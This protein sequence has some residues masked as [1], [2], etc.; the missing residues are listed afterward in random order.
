MFTI[1]LGNFNAKRRQRY[2]R[3]NTFE[4]LTSL[5]NFDW[6]ISKPTRIVFHSSSC[7]DLIFTNQTN[8]VVN[9]GA[10]STLNTKCYHQITHC[11]INLNIEC[12]PYE[13]LVWDY[14]KASTESIK[15]SIESVNWKTLFSSITLNKQA[16][17]F[18]ETIANVFFSNFIPKKLDSFDDSNPPWMNYVIENNIKWKHQLYKTYQKMVV[19]TVTISNYKK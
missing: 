11:K 19:K 10:H 8:L 7:T 16:S 4:A 17:I 18:N 3:K 9:C 15:K 5:H 2:S 14:K 1:I 6:L 12:P 13:R